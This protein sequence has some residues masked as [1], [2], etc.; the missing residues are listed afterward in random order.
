MKQSSH[1][2]RR[3]AG[4]ALALLSCW[5]GTAL[6]QAPS[7]WPTKPLRV[8]VN[9]PPGGAADPVTTCHR[10]SPAAAG[11]AAAGPAPRAAGPPPP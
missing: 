8:V 7:A 9:F 3:A 11:G 2:T 10:L 6:A 5:T 4:L 1:L